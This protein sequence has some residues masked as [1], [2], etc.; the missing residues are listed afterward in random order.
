MI[1]GTSAALATLLALAPARAVRAPLDSQVVLER[2]AA[3]L[4][5]AE[6]PKTI[7]FTYVVS[8][9]GP[10]D[11]DQTHRLYRS[12][13]LVRDETL[14][15]D[16]QKPPV[17]LIRIARYRNRYTLRALAPRLT[18]YAFLFERAAR[19]GTHYTYLYRAVALTPNPAFD[20]DA[21]TIDGRTFLPLQIA[22]RSASGRTSAKGLLTFT[23]AG[24]YW[25][26]SSVTVGATIGGKAARERIAFTGY[27]FPMSLPRSTFQSPKPLPKLLLPAF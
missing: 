11:I 5:T 14:I 22:F 17:K 13:E 10:H 16:G 9:A 19:A 1:V 12:G 25:V 18:Q 24:K 27:L 8:Q 6:E 20:V 26:P 7:I 23:A 3:K 15:V 21:L 2:Y 4:L